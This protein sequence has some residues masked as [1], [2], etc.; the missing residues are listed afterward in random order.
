MCIYNILTGIFGIFSLFMGILTLL[1][2]PM[3]TAI[4][5]DRIFAGFFLMGCAFTALFLYTSRLIEK[6]K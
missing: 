5:N 3:R 6:S 2:Q 4:V 1:T